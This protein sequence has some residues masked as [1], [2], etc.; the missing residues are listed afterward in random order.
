MEIYWG[1]YRMHIFVFLTLL[2][3]CVPRLETPFFIDH[4]FLVC[5][6][7]YR[8]NSRINYGLEI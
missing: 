7:N 6:F 1:S 3:I 4:Y 5:I 8:T 2:R